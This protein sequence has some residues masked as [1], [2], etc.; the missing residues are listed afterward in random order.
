MSAIRERVSIGPLG[1]RKRILES[2]FNNHF[3]SRGVIELPPTS[4]IFQEKWNLRLCSVTNQVTRK[5]SAD[6]LTRH[7]FL[8]LEPR[9]AKNWKRKD[10]NLPS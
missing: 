6:R 1:S 5:K 4:S 7:L 9:K 3:S 10:E 8:G 2:S